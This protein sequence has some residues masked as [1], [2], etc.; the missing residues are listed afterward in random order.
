MS[1]RAPVNRMRPIH[2]GEF[3]REDYLK[4][5]GLTAHALALALRVP[6]S[7]INDIVLERRAVTADTALRLAR[8]FGGDAQ[9]WINLQAEYDLKTAKRDSGPAIDR[10]VKPRAA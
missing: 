1:Q 7:R 3:L 8:H 4:P 10:E 2:P 5:L 6:A 9:T